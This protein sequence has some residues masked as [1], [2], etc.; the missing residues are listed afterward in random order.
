MNT[1]HLI[2]ALI[3]ALIP[4]FPAQAADIKTPS[5]PEQIV[6]PVVTTTSFSWTGFYLGAQLGRLS[7]KVSATGRNLGAPLPLNE[8]NRR[9]DWTPVE[10]KY[11]PN[12]SGFIGGIY[13]GV[14]VDLGMNFIFGVDTDILLSERKGTKTVALVDE[15]D[16]VAF[17]HTLKQK[18]SGATRARIAHST[19]CI[20]PYLA[21]GITYGHFQDTFSGALLGIADGDALDIKLDETKTMV[22]YTLGV[23]VDFAVTSNAVLRAEYRYSDFGKKKFHDIIDIDYKTNDFRVG[24]AYKF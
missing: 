20:M 18:W 13:A 2:T 6:P 11:L 1:K 9:S 22:G 14:N 3:S 23:G 17:G 7:G 4:A 21:G 16:R 24:L 19:G 5:Q 8:D 12:L 10:E 15:S